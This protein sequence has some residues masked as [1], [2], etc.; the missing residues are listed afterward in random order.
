M[1][2]YEALEDIRCLRKE[3]LAFVN[4]MKSWMSNE[5]IEDFNKL[6]KI[7]NNMISR[8]EDE[9]LAEDICPNCGGEIKTKHINDLDCGHYTVTR[10]IDCQM[11][12]D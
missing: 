8:Y 4:T 5:E 7:F 9:C 12:F 10:C 3:T 1:E 11:S 6:K 2:V